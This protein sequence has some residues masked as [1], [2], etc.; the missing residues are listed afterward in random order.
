M[1]T[2]KLRNF[3]RYES[4]VTILGNICLSSF[5]RSVVKIHIVDH[6]LPAGLI[7]NTELT[8]LKTNF[9]PATEE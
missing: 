6:E 4:R 2:F 3:C 1:L 9:E 7:H 5:L 8:V